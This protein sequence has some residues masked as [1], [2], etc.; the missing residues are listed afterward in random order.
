[1]PEPDTFA[2]LG[3]QPPDK[4]IVGGVDSLTPQPISWAAKNDAFN[5]SEPPVGGTIARNPDS[6]T[7]N[8]DPDWN[9]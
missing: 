6:A 5:A 2:V 1:M 3:V 8:Y 9:K 7:V 4:R